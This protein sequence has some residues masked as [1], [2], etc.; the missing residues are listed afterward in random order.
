MSVKARR[1]A[2]IAGLLSL[3]LVASATSPAAAGRKHVC[4]GPYSANGA[5]HFA[6][7]MAQAYDTDW[8]NTP[9]HIYGY[10]KVSNNASSARTARY[11]IYIRWK[12][13]G[14]SSLQPWK[15]QSSQS[16]TVPAGGAIYYSRQ[17]W[18][19]ALKCD[20]DPAGG[21]RTWVEIRVVLTYGSQ[22]EVKNEIGAPC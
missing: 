2:V 4:Q 13:A 19:T 11:K 18:Y 20:T 1:R 7:C 6:A 10:V 12:Y 8:V 16:M 22:P 15:L 5:L 21:G 9:E 17:G 14:F 3:L